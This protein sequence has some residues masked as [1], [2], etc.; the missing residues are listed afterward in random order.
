MELEAVRALKR[1]LLADAEQAKQTCSLCSRDAHSRGLCNAHYKSE[2]RAGRLFTVIRPKGLTL[3]DAFAWYMPGDP[4]D[5]GC[6]DWA[7]PNVDKD[8]Y[9][10][11]AW[12]IGNM[13]AHR[14]SYEIFNGV[15]PDDLLVLHICDRPV[16][17][18]PLHLVVGTNDDN[19]SDMVER[20]RALRGVEHHNAK[21]SP[22]TVRELRRL[23]E[24][25]HS[26]KSLARRFDVSDN[27]VR[28]V[29]AKETWAH[30][31]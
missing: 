10:L 18:Q 20:E 2:R 6:W 23:F 1:Q 22:D 30:V 11:F 26:K 16:C 13:R 31:D 9:G 17:V 19:M 29:L 3:I 25:G 8:G 27:A 15:I 4:P 12:G 14:A 28:R 24:E 5:H 7:S 21:F